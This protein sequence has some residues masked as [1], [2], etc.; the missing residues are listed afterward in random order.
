MRKTRKKGW[1][2]LAAVMLTLTLVLA[3]CSGGNNSNNGTTS[4]SVS[5]TSSGNEELNQ[6]PPKSAGPKTKIKF[7]AHQ[8]N[9]KDKMTELIA[10]Y[11]ASNTDGIEIELNV[12]ADKYND[13]LSL[14][15]T[16]G[17]GPD[18]FTIAGPSGTR[19]WADNKWAEPL[20][21]YITDEF[22]AQLR[23]GV[24]VGNNN[25][26]GGQIY[27]LP[28]VA[29]TIRL[30]YN[31]DL[32]KQAGLDP[33][34]P[35]TTFAELEDYA[36]KIK[37]ATG[38]AGY[39]LPMADGYNIDISLLNSMGYNAIGSARGFDHKQGKFDFTGFAPLLQLFT[40]M[41]K[42]GSMLEGALLVNGDQGR[43]KFAEGAIGMIGGASWDPGIYASMDLK[44]EVGVADFPTID[45]TAKGKP[46]LSIGSG[47]MMSA[48]AK[49]KEKAWKAL[50]FI[51]SPE[52]MGEIVKVAGGL[53]LVKEVA[54]NPAYK[55]DIPMLEAFQ[56]TPSDAVWPPFPPGLKLQGDPVQNVFIQVINGQLSV[57]DAIADLNKRYNEAFELSISQGAFKREEFMMPGLDP[58]AL[59]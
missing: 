16:S 32:F 11:N 13:V 35:P 24:W 33:E 21:A 58:L 15:F 34:K 51:Y 23:D 40:D 44:F 12:V 46:N 59:K 42:N 7:W 20:N 6:S 27:T 54:D 37:E 4:P 10:A 48:V 3:A 36:K 28:D 45:G 52:F 50:E 47:Y 57:D 43:A 1:S 25:V 14:A 5:P 19:K 26:I 2:S 29:T 53:S 17:E 9:L 41:H 38:A 8:N 49:D 55:A 31:K 22:K 18:I 56:P 30:L 39:G